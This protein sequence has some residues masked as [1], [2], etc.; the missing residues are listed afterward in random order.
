MIIRNLS[1]YLNGCTN[2][3]ELRTQRNLDQ[4]IVML[5]GN[6]VQNSKEEKSGVSARVRCNGSWGFASATDMDEETI[7]AVIESA[8]NNANLLGSK[9]SK[10]SE[11]FS[12]FEDSVEKDLSTKKRRS[13]QSEVMGFLKE[14]DEYIDKKYTDL[15]SR[16]VVL[17]TLDMEKNLITSQGASAYTFTPR[18]FVYIAMKIEKNGEVTEVGGLVGDAG[19]FED[20]FESTEKIFEKIDETYEHLKKKCDGVFAE[21]GLKECILDADLA[22]ILAHEAIGHTTEAD[23]VLGG[24]VAG[25]YLNEKVASELITLVDFANTALG[26]QCPIPIYI[27]DEGVTA[28]D[29]TI[30]EDGVLKSFMHNRDSANYFDVEA[31]GNGRAYQ[32]NDEPLIRMRNTAI[33]PGKSKLEDMIAS[34]EDGYYLIKPSNGQA[35]STSEFMFGVT[36]GYEIKNGKLGRAIKDTTISGVAFDVLKTVTMVS[37]D[38]SWSAAGM[39]GKKQ[40]IPVGMG[41]PAIKCKINIGGR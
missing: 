13:T 5:N 24:S 22:G 41:G 36:L 15:S 19:Q 21:A 18:S 26:K 11:G 25:D 3:T 10:N 39:C 31:T 20:N 40:P 35:D 1:E 2:Y 29:V 33:L 16:T 23:I 8:N 32:F 14:V 9:I 38:M 34:I 30:I 6:M 27:D 28:K 4:R 12:V 7:K 37:D 17:S